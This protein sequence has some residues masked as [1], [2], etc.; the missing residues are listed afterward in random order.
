MVQDPITKGLRLSCGGK[1]Y[2]VEN[3]DGS[4]IPTRIIIIATG[5]GIGGCDY[6]ICNV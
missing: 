2:I 3:E 5:A 4:K 6:K 1:P